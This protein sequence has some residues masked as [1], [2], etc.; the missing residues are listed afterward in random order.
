MANNQSVSI[1]PTSVNKGTTSAK[2]LSY[3]SILQSSSKYLNAHSTSLAQAFPLILFAG[4]V[5]FRLHAGVIVVDG[6]RLRYSMNDWK[7]IMAVKLLRMRLKEIVAAKLKA[8]GKSL[9]RR[10]ERWRE[11][12]QD[13]FHARE[14]TGKK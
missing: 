2:F 6:N 5:D 13:V 11:V 9:G 14:A 10:L 1:H 7:G 8:P 3:Y 4:N 12:V